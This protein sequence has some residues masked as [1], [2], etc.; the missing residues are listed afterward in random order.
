M[1][2]HHHRHAMPQ[3]PRDKLPIVHVVEIPPACPTCGSRD[4]SPFENQQT[5]Q[6]F[7]NVTL[8]DGRTIAAD[9]VWA[10]TTCRACEQRYRVRCVTPVD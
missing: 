8:P 3:P 10:Y 4:R 9:I 5:P 2:R 7:E 6:R 1:N